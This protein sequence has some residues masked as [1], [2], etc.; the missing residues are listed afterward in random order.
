VAFASAG[1]K[2]EGRSQVSG[3]HPLGAG[4]CHFQV[5]QWR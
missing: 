5:H 4:R 3:R 2:H 1:T